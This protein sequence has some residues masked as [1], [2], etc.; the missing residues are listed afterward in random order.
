MTC[1]GCRFRRN[2]FHQTAIAANS[3]DVVVEDL[4]ARLIVA[5][6]EKLLADRH[7][8]ARGNTLAQWTSRSFDARHPVVLGMSGGLAIELAEAADVV[9][10]YG[11]LSQPFIFA[12]HR[13][14][15][16]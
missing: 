4:E 8:D 16:A 1:Q 3:V 5:A 13:T 9:E 7:A 15:P 10:C 11:R 14:R 12:I 2:A 6:G